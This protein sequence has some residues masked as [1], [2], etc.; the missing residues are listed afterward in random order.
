L[1]GEMTD[2]ELLQL[3][4]A[5]TMQR[6]AESSFMHIFLGFARC[7]QAQ[8]SEECAQHAN[9]QKRLVEFPRKNGFSVSF[10]SSKKLFLLE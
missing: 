2:L 7:K 10:S 9:G 8:E 4:R 1:N 3:E 6:R 5:Q